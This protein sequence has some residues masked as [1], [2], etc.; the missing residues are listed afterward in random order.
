MRLQIEDSE[1]AKRLRLEAKAVLNCVYGN[2]ERNG[3][4]TALQ[5]AFESSGICLRCCGCSVAEHSIFRELVI[6]RLD[7]DDA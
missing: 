5:A 7:A 2:R 4:L 1:I 3:T 6:D